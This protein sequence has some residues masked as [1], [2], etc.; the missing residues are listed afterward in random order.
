MGKTTFCYPPLVEH[1]G[2]PGPRDG[3]N[4]AMTQILLP[5]RFESSGPQETLLLGENIVDP[6]VGTYKVVPQFVS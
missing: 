4:D 1:G 3:S 5:G 6:T 2:H